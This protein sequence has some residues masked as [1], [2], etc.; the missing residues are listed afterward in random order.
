MQTNGQSKPPGEWVRRHSRRN[1]LIL[2]GVGFATTITIAVTTH[3]GLSMLS[4]VRAYVGG[5]GLWS[6]A[7]KDAVNWLH[8]YAESRDEA[9]YRAYRAS[10]QVPLG[11]RMAREELEKPQFDFEVVRRGFILG[12]NHPDDVRNMA[13]L[14]RYFRRVRYMQRAIAIWERGDMEIS[15]LVEAGQRL[16]AAVQAGAAREAL[17]PILAEIDAVNSRVTP[18]EDDF[19]FTLGEAARWAKGLVLELVVGAAALLLLLS[20]VVVQRLGRE[21]A[22]SEKRYRSVTETVT[23][24]ILSIDERGR[25]LLANSA[26][27]RIFGRPAARLVGANFEDLLPEELLEEP[28]SVLR[29]CLESAGSQDSTAAVRLRA[30]HQDGHEI[31]LEVSF[32]E[33]REGRRRVFTGI[34]RDITLRTQEEE[35]IQRL[36]YHDA[37]TGL[38]NRALFQD[39]LTQAL[40][41]ARRRDEKIAVM[42]LDLDDFKIINDSFGHARGDEVLREVGGRLKSDLR[43]Q[44]T[45]ARMGGDEFIVFLPELED[46]QAAA[47]AAEKI[48]GTIARPIG[49]EGKTVTVTASI[50]I[51]LFPADGA[52]PETLVRNADIAMYRAK[53]HGDSTFEFYSPEHHRLVAV[54]KVERKR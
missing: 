30:I 36:A 20:A 35:Q 53:E 27:A 29:R 41:R 6:K 3:V 14:F 9:A 1:T 21:I 28:G 46:V 31:P 5:E 10:I 49:L 33:E 4:G 51:S 25:I 8:R 16:H 24:G 12:R 45:A 42:F 22:T 50:G 17:T 7:Q 19:S 37:L 23:D 15:A 2:L 48:L 26:A 44:D 32:A 47:L 40:S 39:R 52:D 43:G 18:L 11:D 38:P 13:L 34:V 54:D